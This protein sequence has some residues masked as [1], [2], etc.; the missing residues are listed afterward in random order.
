MPFRKKKKREYPRIATPAATPAIC[1]ICN[2]I[3]NNTSELTT[4]VLRKY[5]ENRMRFPF[6]CKE[7]EEALWKDISKHVV[8]FNKLSEV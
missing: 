7:E 8:L 6:G 4:L 5:E 2:I 3:L 1:Q